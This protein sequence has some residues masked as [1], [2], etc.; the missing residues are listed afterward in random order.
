MT[1]GSKPHGLRRTASDIGLTF[2]R[3][4]LAG[5]IQLGIFLVVARNLG[6]EGA[7]AFAIA[8]LVPMLMT[9]LLNLGLTAANIYFVA[10]KRFPLEQAWT[11][12]RDLMLAVAAVGLGL[13]TIIILGLREWAFSGLERGV[14]ITAMLVFPL[15]LLSTLAIGFF[16]ALENFGAF[17]LAVLVQPTIA[18]FG[19][20][21][22]WAVGEFSLLSVIFIV[23]LSHLIGLVV[24]LLLLSREVSISVRSKN[25]AEYLR[26]ALR[27]GSKAYLGNFLQFLNYRLDL[28]FVY[29]MVGPAAAG[30]YNVAVRMAEQL[31]MVSQA[32]STVIFPRLSAM[33]TDQKGRREFTATMARGIMWVTLFGAGVLAALANPL[34]NLL[35]GPEFK[36]AKSALTLLLPGVVLLACARVLAN[37]IAARGLVSIN[38]GLAALVLVIN[39]AANILLI[40]KFGVVGAAAA[41]TLAYTVHFIVSVIV[42]CILTRSK[43]WH[44]VFP[45]TANFQLLKRALSKLIKV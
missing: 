13:G 18:F 45:T 1:T 3:Q 38:L 8:L 10:S 23:V 42:Q 28:F 35:F 16:Q 29:L 2:G 40:P 39:I 22:I 19:I 44:F 15:S 4:F 27:Y 20:I 32:A 31:W 33:H 43:W 12:S 30:I 6:P 24:V 26:P 36:S 34:I 41:T 25:R 11:A 37:D 9:Q 7:G 21:V 17:N 14:L 5:F